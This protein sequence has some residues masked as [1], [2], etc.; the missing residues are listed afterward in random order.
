MNPEAWLRNH[1][2]G[3][4]LSGA[5]RPEDDD[6]DP[7]LLEFTRLV[8]AVLRFRRIREDALDAPPAASGRDWTRS[9]FHSTP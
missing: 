5:S 1:L 7:L 8:L 3:E 2:N 6:V 4:E 9:P